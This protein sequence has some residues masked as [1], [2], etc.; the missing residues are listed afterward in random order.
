MI[1][2]MHHG[3]EGGYRGCKLGPKD[4]RGFRTNSQILGLRTS[5]VARCSQVLEQN[6]GGLKSLLLD[7]IEETLDV[8]GF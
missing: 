1:A 4:L 5:L 3:N 8:G 7:E 2:A 6:L